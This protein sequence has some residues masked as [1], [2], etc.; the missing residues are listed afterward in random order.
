MSAPHATVPDRVEHLPRLETG[1]L[2]AFIDQAPVSMAMF[3]R[4][5][6]YMAASQRWIE[7]LCGGRRDVIGRSHYEVNPEVPQHW[8]EFH[9]RALAG[10][11][12]GEERERLQRQ[13][14]S[15]MWV[16]WQAC[17]WHDAGGEIGGITVVGED[18]TAEVEREQALRQGTSALARLHDVG[19]RLRLAGSLREGLDEMLLATIELLGGVM[20]HVHMLDADGKTLRLATQYGFAPDVPA[21]LHAISAADDTPDGRALR[22]RMPVAIADTESDDTYTAF[23]SVAREADYRA[24]VKAPLI[25]RYGTPLGII[26]THFRVPHRPTDDDLQRLEL[27]RRRAADFIERFNA[28]EA[29]R[30]SNAKLAAETKAMAQFYEAGLRLWEAKSLQEGLDA[31]LAGTI[32]LLGADMGTVQLFDSGS[33]LLRLVAHRGF[34]QEFLDYFHEASPEQDTAFGRALRSGKL[35]VIE[36]TERDLTAQFRAIRRA[37]DYRSIVAAPLINSGGTLLGMLSVHFRAP[38]RLGDSELQWLE[39]YRRRAADFIQRVGTQEA[40]REGEERLRLAIE[41]AHLAT[42]DR[43]ARTDAHVWNDEFYRIFGY[44]VGE[45]EASHAAWARRVHP[46]DRAAAEAVVENA[47][48]EHTDY[49]NEFRVIRPDGSVRWVRARGRYLY[50][51]GEPLRSIGLVEDITEA[52]QQIE[53]QRVLVAELQHRTRNLMAVVQSIAQQTRDSVDTLAEFEDRFDERLQAL[54]RVQSLLSRADNEPIT[55]GALVVM[56]LDALGADT[57]GDKIS[58]GGPETPL[59][60]SAVEMLALAIHELL[61]NALKHGALASPTGRL[62]VNWRID[63]TLPD[64]RLVLEWAEYGV[65]RLP[66]STDSERSGYGRTLIEEALPYSLSAQTEFELS[67]DG[68]RCRISL[69]LSPNDAAEIA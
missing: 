26:S 35:M 39:L 30:Q 15:A 9:Q 12:L 14:G 60:K 20:G 54:S 5:M 33:K 58:Y 64:R 32:D 2:R 22:M 25:G 46:D 43:D 11:K 24:V 16:R 56:E 67:A 10:E 59:R 55:L 66:P 28:D 3:D 23:R 19:W 41:T 6:R 40:L 57:M 69:P 4:E 53:T 17:P 34:K 27:Y 13:D 31:T 18:V 65:A 38:H 62:V 29:L 49:V 63:E 61:T 7:R 37:A 51:D 68:L 21:L 44:E 50:Y 42:W 52:R 36:D 48:R 8:R 47:D 45:I 1:N